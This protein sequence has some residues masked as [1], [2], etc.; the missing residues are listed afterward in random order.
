MK[1]LVTGASGYIGS[2]T[3]VDL[4]ENGFDVVSVDNFSN[5]YPEALEGVEQITGKK[6]KHYTLDICNKSLLEEIFDKEQNISGIIHFAAKKYVSESV[7]KPSL[8]YHNN[9]ETLL[10]ILDCC[11]KFN[12]QHFVFSSSCSV[13][14][15]SSSIFSPST[16][17]VK[18]FFS[19]RITFFFITLFAA[20]RIVCV[21]L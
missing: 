10:N 15:I 18:R 13:Y 21:D 14:E 12:I 16:F 9:I 20:I 5:S 8:Y 2:H 19:G 17:L 1:I 6:I 4:I 11:N 3:L 7:E